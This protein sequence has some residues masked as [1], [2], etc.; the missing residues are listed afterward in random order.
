[1]N[2]SSSVSHCGSHAVRIWNKVRTADEIAAT[3]HTALTGQGTGLVACYPF[4]QTDDPYRLRD[5]GPCGLHGTIQNAASIPAAR[6][7]SGRCSPYP[8]RKTGLETTHSSP[9][10]KAPPPARPGKGC[11]R[12]RDRF[13]PSLVERQDGRERGLH[14]HGRVGDIAEFRHITWDMVIGIAVGPGAD[15]DDRRPEAGP[16]E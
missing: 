8:R 6:R 15:V 13:L 16:D 14:G 11:G 5:P 7:R 10:V 2:E 4:V 12:P 9:Q 1:V 3:W